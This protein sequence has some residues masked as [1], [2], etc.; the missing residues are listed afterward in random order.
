MGNASKER[1]DLIKKVYSKTEYPKVID[2]KF[3]Q[4]GVI[5]IPSQ[6]EATFTVEEFFQKYNDIFY[7]IPAFGETNSHEYLV[8]T[9]GDYINFD[10][11]N[12]I[13]AALQK[14]IAQLRQDLLQEQIKTAE[15][16][17][18]EKINLN[19]AESVEEISDF[20]SISTAFTNQEK[21]NPDDTTTPPDDVSTSGVANSN[22]QY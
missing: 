5:S 14:E 6:I 4:L 21:A 2:T 22:S 12:E 15:A 9:S 17:T 1:V 7:E 11:D 16:I 20:Q 19:V 18:G 10:E 8:R 3:S 13:I